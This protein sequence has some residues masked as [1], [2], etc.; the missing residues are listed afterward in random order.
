MIPVARLWCG[1]AL[2]TLAACQR[3]PVT[4]GAPMRLPDA[5]LQAAGVQWSIVIPAA[6]GY[7][8][9]RPNAPTTMPLSN[10]CP[11][12]IVAARTSGGEWFAAWWRARPDSSVSLMVTRSEDGGGTWS[13][14]RSAD[15]RD[16]GRRGCAR[17]AAAIAGDSLTGYIH[18]AYFLEP[19]EGAGVWLT[20]SME[21]GDMWHGPVA[22]A[23][24]ADPAFASVA[25]EGDTVAVAYESPNSNE[26]WIDLALSTSDG[27]LIDWRLPAVSGRSVP[28]EAPRVA[29][30]AHQV[31]V[32]WVTQRGAL[33]MATA[34]TRR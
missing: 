17:P 4:W 14:P 34:G 15:A 1:T 33:A 27:H 32:A 8:L 29:V 11:G 21:H 24:G 22:L 30:R 20:H 19:A 23:F 31:A 5:A 25:A 2:L 26:G 3:E 18:L 9:E 10:G 13:P 28:A 7:A 16:R 12:S 6:G